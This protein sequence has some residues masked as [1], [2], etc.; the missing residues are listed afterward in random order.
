MAWYK[1]YQSIFQLRHLLTVVLWGKANLGYLEAYVSVYSLV[2]AF[3]IS[4]V[5]EEKKMFVSRDVGYRLNLLVN[6]D[7]TPIIPN[8]SRFPS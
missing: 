6:I 1:Q 3:Q 2:S 7:N 4:H 5:C 8:D